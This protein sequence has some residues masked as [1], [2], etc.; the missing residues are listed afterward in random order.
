MTWRDWTA[1]LHL[2][3]LAVAVVIVAA[4]AALS[5]R[6][7]AFVLPSPLSVLYGLGDIL[8][9]GEIWRHTG[10]SLARIAVLQMA[11]LEP[12]AKELGDYFEQIGAKIPSDESLRRKV[13]EWRKS[14]GKS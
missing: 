11:K 1:R 2:P 4:W 7:G 9:S 12:T 14:D 6:Y 5:W 10:A 3:T 13:R 8:R